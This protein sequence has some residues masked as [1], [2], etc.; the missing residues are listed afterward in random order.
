MT[1]SNIDTVITGF[2]ERVERVQAEIA[3]LNADKADIFKEAR[4]QGFD[5]NALKS[6]MKERAMDPHKRIERNTILDQYRKACG[7]Q[8]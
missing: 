1:Q 7:L 6:V 8:D 2:I 4:A 5:V 3:E